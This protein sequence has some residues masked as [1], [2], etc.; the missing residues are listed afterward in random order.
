MLS[1]QSKRRTAALA[2]AILGTLVAAC[3]SDTASPK[4]VATAIEATSSLTQSATV[5]TAATAPSVKAVTSTGAPVPGVTV[6]FTAAGGGS[7]GATSAT[8]GTDG[9]ATAGS[10]T[11]GTTA[12]ANTV[13]ATATGLTPVTFTATGV[14]GAA[15][16]AAVSSGNSQTAAVGTAVATAPAVV[17]KDQYGNPVAGAAVTFAVD[18]GGGAVTGATTTTGADGIAKVGTWTLGITA[19]AQRL[20]A[21]SGALSATFDATGIVPA[22]CAIT[23]YALGATLPLTW[24]ADDCVATTSPTGA[25]VTGKRYDRLQFTTT[26]QQ[27]IDAAVTGTSGRMLLLRNA[28]TGLYVGLQ[29]STA[30]SPAAQNPMHLKYVLP[31]GSWVFEPYAPDAATTGAYSLT[32][33]TNTKVNCDY[34]VFATPGVTIADSVVNTTYNCTGPTG[35]MEQWVNLQLRTGMKVRLTL[36]PDFPALFILR[37]DRQGPASPT[38]VSKQGTAGQTLVIDWTATFD[39][40]HEIIVA[41]LNAAGGKY[42]LKIEELP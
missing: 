38:L 8:T 2:A 13:T 28:A 16:S 36:T 42:T 5:G 25:S 6:T 9:V 18:L 41:P 19:G 17:I 24:E 29:P 1:V 40:W 27:Q 21:T 12:G 10:W 34:I 20:K 23:N 30:F 35:F 37:D 3:G 11:L 14:A 4:P 39:S 26:A 33:T 32:T 7:L 15:A 22:G 31:A